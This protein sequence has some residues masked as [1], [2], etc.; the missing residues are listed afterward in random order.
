MFVILLGEHAVITV[1]HKTVLSGGDVNIFRENFTYQNGINIA[2]QYLDGDFP[3]ST[4][5]FST[6][7]HRQLSLV[8]KRGTVIGFGVKPVESI[9]P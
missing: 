4:L 3:I 9:C 7:M 8:V 1:S 6:P 2:N 5:T